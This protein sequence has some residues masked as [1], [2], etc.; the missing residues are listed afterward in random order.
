MIHKAMEEWGGKY[1]TIVIPDIES[2]CYGREVGY[3]IKGI[4]LDP[5]VEA[6]SGTKIRNGDMDNG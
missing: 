2:V 1:R 3:E 5:E 4:R 6:I